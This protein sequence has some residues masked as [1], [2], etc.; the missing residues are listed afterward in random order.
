MIEKKVDSSEKEEV[1]EH[2]ME[3][4]NLLPEAADRVALSGTSNS[5]DSILNEVYKSKRGLESL[6]TLPFCSHECT[7]SEGVVAE[8]PNAQD[9]F[10]GRVEEVLQENQ[11]E[12][13]DVQNYE[14]SCDKNEGNSSDMAA[15]YEGITTKENYNV[16]DNNSK[17]D[18]ATLEFMSDIAYEKSMSDDYGNGK[19][20]KETLLN[21]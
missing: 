7:L 21:L 13:F 16:S 14:K 9:K 18:A 6:S 3:D 15:I 10:V 20:E 1:A 5:G 17:S 2:S 19:N 11:S 8:I 12:K 4:S